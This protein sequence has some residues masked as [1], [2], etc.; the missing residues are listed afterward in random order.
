MLKTNIIKES[1]DLIREDA[2]FKRI[3]NSV[4]TKKYFIEGVNKFGVYTR[5]TGYQ[6]DG[7]VYLLGHK[8]SLDALLEL[9]VED[10]EMDIIDIESVNVVLYLIIFLSKE[11]KNLKCTAEYIRLTAQFIETPEGKSWVKENF[12]TKDKEKVLSELLDVSCSEVKC[13]LKL[14]KSGNENYLKMLENGECSL[15]H[16]Y[17]TCCNAENEQRIKGAGD[18]DGSTKLASKKIAKVSGAAKPTLVTGEGMF[19][20]D[21]T[22]E[23]S[24]LIAPVSVA[25]ELPT[26]EDLDS[27]L[28]QYR[29]NP[30]A[31]NAVKSRLIQKVVLFLSDGK[32]LEL[33]VPAYLT[34]DGEEVS[35]TD[36]LK[37]STD[38]NWTLPDVC[39]SW[40][41]TVQP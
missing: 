32:Q 11:H 23:G 27:I 33:V 22:I 20:D 36:R 4:I 18:L 25:N 9:G 6:K 35:S 39:Q 31:E 14:I 21:T 37:S 40:Y 8:S 26:L 38:G 5:P 30:V 10:I 41:L 12:Q 34:I 3:W 16:A 2:T 7:H 29:Q 15:F 17:T 1:A 13:Y 19:T 24:D 28:N